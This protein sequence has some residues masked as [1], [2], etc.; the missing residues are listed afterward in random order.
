MR[1]FPNES[2]SPRSAADDTSETTVLIVDDEKDLADLYTAWLSERYEVK[3]AYS[4]SDAIEQLS[5]SLDVVFLDRRMPSVSG[6]EVLKAIRDRG[7]D[8]SVAMVTGV[9][10][11]FDIIEMGFDNYLTKPISREELH[12]T[13]ESL[14]SVR[15]YDSNIDELFSL[16]N[17]QSVLKQK[18]S[19]EELA[20]NEEYQELV[21]RIDRLEAEMD[22]LVA[23]L[24]TSD[25]DALL[26]QLNA[27]SARADD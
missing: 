1:E 3:T 15:R 17:K 27:P 9:E 26:R 16:L 19:D 14:L 24:T 13:V 2:P 21:R 10:P 23:D 4:G 5:E 7:I 11:D 20:A 6:D 22:T 8:C 25:W 18:K 12:S